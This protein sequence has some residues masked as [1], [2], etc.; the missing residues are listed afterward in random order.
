[1][2]L[3]LPFELAL[4]YHI[5]SGDVVQ[6]SKLLG[7]ELVQTWQHRRL[8]SILQEVNDHQNKTVA[9]NRAVSS[10]IDAVIAGP[11]LDDQCKRTNTPIH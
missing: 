11:E 6:M 8:N 9:R 5:D 4:L 10:I 7:H 1:M 3:R 2:I